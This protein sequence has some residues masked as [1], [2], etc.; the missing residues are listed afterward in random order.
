MLKKIAAAIGF[1]P[2]MEALLIEAG[3][4]HQ[5][6]EVRHTMAACPC[7]GLKINIKVAVG[8]PGVA[9]AKFSRFTE[10]HL[11][12]MEAP[13]RRLNIFDRIFPK[14]LE[15]LPADLPGIFLLVQ[16]D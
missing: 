16:A 5:G 4:L 11:L 2:R 9:L 13:D 8:K 10:A 1:S 14:K 15:Y 12:I 6:E 3:W 7:Q